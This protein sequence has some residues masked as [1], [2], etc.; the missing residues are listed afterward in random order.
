MSHPLTDLIARAAAWHA[1]GVPT[2]L[3]DAH[4]AGTRSLLSGLSDL[5]DLALAAELGFTAV[6]GPLFD[7]AA[8]TVWE[9]AVDRRS[10]R[11]A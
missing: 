11:V 5:G 3:A 10:A 9:S 4:C 2:T 6:S 7:A 8:F 1:T